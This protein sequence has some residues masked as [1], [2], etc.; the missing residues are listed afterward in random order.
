[1]IL[2]RTR[3]YNIPGGIKIVEFEYGTNILTSTY[4]LGDNDIFK[5]D[6]GELTGD[7]ATY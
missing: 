3:A 6:A 7:M 5:G 4:L 2:R 1:L